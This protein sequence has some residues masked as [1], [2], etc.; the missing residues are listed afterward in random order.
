[1]RVGSVADEPLESAVH[2]LHLMRMLAR[3]F[4]ATLAELV[5]STGRPEAEVRAA[6][7]RLEANHGIVLHPGTIEPWVIHPFSTTQSDCGTRP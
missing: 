7:T 2:R 4:P 1:M 5:E 6:V 3:G